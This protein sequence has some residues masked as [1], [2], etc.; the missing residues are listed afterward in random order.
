LFYNTVEANKT[1]INTYTFGQDIK[2]LY[3]NEPQLAN[4]V[5][6]DKNYNYILFSHNFEKK[7]IIAD[8]W[9][10]TPAIT[11]ATSN[12]NI[13]SAF[14]RVYDDNNAFILSLHQVIHRMRAKP[15]L[16]DSRYLILSFLS[17]NV[18]SFAS[19]IPQNHRSNILDIGCG[20]KPYSVLLEKNNNIV[21]HIGIDLNKKSRADAIAIGENI[22]F[23]ECSF[24]SVFCTQALEHTIDPA[25]VVDETF[26]VL[27]YDGSLLLSTHGVWIEGHENPDNWRWTRTG[28]TKLIGKSGYEV[29]SCRSMPPITSVAQL[30][31]L[32]VPESLP[33]KLTIIPAINLVAI[34]LEKILKSRGPKIHLVHVIRA[35]KKRK[36]ASLSTR[37]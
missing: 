21:N 24:T 11:N 6:H 26:R 18:N 5:F 23:K 27:E 28:L 22:P 33:S 17:K 35:T 8:G 34:V 13:N 12:L 36:S 37:F 25:K 1:N 4:S 3:S 7:P 32:Y 9:F 15:K 14:N 10:I 31:L 16:K 30:S 19:E 20:M 29:E 2:M